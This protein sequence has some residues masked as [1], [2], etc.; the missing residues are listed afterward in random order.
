MNLEQFNPA[1]AQWLRPD[2]SVGFVT[3]YS[4]FEAMDAVVQPGVLELSYPY[5]N[6]SSNF[7][8]LVAPNPLNAPK[9]VYSWDEVV[10]VNV[11]V[12]GNVNLSPTVGFCGLVGG[13]CEVIKYVY[14]FRVLLERPGH[15]SPTLNP[16]SS[17]SL[18][19]D[20]RR[21]A[22]FYLQRLRV[23]EFH[24]SHALK[25]QRKCDADDTARH[26]QHLWLNARML[27][28]TDQ[29]RPSPWLVR[30]SIERTPSLVFL[31]SRH[32]GRSKTSSTLASSAA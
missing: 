10:G 8:L 22:D 20:L 18:C 11:T 17:R 26:R 3:L 7:T 31:P 32:H 13:V 14:V 25:L 23:L 9:D 6:C 29:R 4:E 5:G 19:S 16:I 30:R 27:K 24:V 15:S 28:T 12:S 1:V 2:G 21:T